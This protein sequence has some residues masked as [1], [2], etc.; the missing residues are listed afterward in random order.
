MTA[1]L[2]SNGFPDVSE[3]TVDRLMREQ[4][5]NGLV[6]VHGAKITVPAKTGGV[7]ASDLLNRVFT[8]PRPN[9]AWATEFPDGT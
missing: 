1:W 6:R 9:H 3:H 4:G 7:R 2:A 5:M 8:A